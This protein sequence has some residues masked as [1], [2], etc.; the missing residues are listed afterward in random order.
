MQRGPPARIVR[1]DLSR[2]EV[3]ALLAEHL[4]HMYAVTP[5]E[6]V[7]ALDIDGLRRPEVTFWT[8]WQGSELL[9]CGALKEIAS[10]HGE[11][12]AM[13]TPQARRGLSAFVEFVKGLGAPQ[14]AQAPQ[15]DSK[16]GQ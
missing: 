4:A 12:K 1:D 2:P 5:P 16:Q 8:L 9:G 3:R 6:S 15:L 7:H 11:V 14:G 10:D 13:R